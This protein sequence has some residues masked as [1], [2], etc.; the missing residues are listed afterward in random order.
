MLLAFHSLSPPRL[1]SLVYNNASSK[2]SKG[3]TAHP[4]YLFDPRLVATISNCFKAKDPQKKKEV[5]LVTYV[6]RFVHLLFSERSKI[7]RLLAI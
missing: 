2:K 5:E 4:T 6:D 3:E 1:I 7:A